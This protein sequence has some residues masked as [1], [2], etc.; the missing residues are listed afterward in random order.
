MSLTKTTSGRKGKGN[1][2]NVHQLGN[3]NKN[4]QYRG[5]CIPQS[6]YS[7]MKRSKPELS[8]NTRRPLSHIV[9][10]KRQAAG[11]QDGIIS[12]EEKKGREGGREERKEGGDGES[13]GGGEDK[14]QEAETIWGTIGRTLKGR[15]DRGH[16]LYIM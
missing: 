10:R 4:K 3:G 14:W 9:E 7:D 15:G 6:C 5:I 16:R 12:G 2:L 8:H 13:R 11:S 1:N